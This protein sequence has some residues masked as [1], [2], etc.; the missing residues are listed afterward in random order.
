MEAGGG[1]TRLAEKRSQL[2]HVGEV[3][4]AGHCHQGLRP[5]PGRVAQI[6][7]VQIDVEQPERFA[8]MVLQLV[9]IDGRSWTDQQAAVAQDRVHLGLQD[10]VGAGCVFHRRSVYAVPNAVGREV[11][12]L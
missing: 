5:S 12:V 7:I 1:G 4:A 9:V 10:Y 3:V 6:F 11:A 2:L 8:K